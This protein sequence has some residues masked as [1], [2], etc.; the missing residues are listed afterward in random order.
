M[1]LKQLFNPAKIYLQEKLS[2]IGTQNILHLK[3]GLS[4]LL[5]AFFRGDICKSHLCQLSRLGDGKGWMDNSGLKIMPR[6]QEHKRFL[7][8]LERMGVFSSIQEK[9]SETVVLIC[10]SGNVVASTDSRCSTRR[11][12]R[13][14]QMAATGEVGKANPVT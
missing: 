14:L 9:K 13:K 6:L 10:L 2:S 5:V 4:A 1:P 12:N 8:L 11:W 7:L 3:H